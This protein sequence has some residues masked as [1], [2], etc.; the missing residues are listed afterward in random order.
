MQKGHLLSSFSHL[1]G[2]CVVCYQCCIYF[3]QVILQED[4]CQLGSRELE[5]D[6][7]RHFV[8]M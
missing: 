6:V 4:L 3:T 1:E 7:C 8:R 2:L 5:Q